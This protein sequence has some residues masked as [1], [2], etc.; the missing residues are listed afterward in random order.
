VVCAAGSL[1]LCAPGAAQQVAMQSSWQTPDSV[2]VVTKHHMILDG[3]TLSYSARAGTLPIRDNATGDVHARIF[4]VSYTLDRNEVARARPLTFVWNGGPGSSSSLVHLL[5]FGPRRIKTGDTYP[6]SPPLSE[7]EWLDNEG[8]WLGQTDLVFVDAVGTGYSRPTKAEFGSE[9]YQTPGDAESIAEFIRV[10]RTR[11]DAWDAPLFIAGESYGVTR[12]AWVA[13]ALE[14][15][16]TRLTG[17]MLFGWELPLGNLSGD[18]R[19]ALALPTYTAAAFYYRKL[20]PDL[21]TN[22]DSAVSRAA[23][24]AQTAYLPAL[25]TRD[26][27]SDAQREQVLAQL[28]RFTGLDSEQLDRK[29]LSVNTR[30]YSRQ[31][32]RNPPRTIGR[33]DSRLWQAQADRAQ[34]SGGDNFAGEV[35]LKPLGRVAGGT[36]FALLRYLR[37]DLGFKS[38]LA[39]AELYDMSGYSPAD[40]GA[41]RSMWRDD[42][43]GVDPSAPLTHAMTLNPDL[44][45]FDACGYYDL[46]SNC[47]GDDYVAAHLDP[48]LARN[49]TTGRYWGGHMMYTDRAVRLAVRRDITQFFQSALAG[50]QTS[51]ATNS[52]PSN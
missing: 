38:D 50:Q 3:R 49:I 14:R 21:Q 28:A 19:H 6:T 25:M 22:L 26:I 24:W 13:D 11:F 51:H 29:T 43:G 12:A 10:Y 30:Q 7:S 35:S 52:T 1:T 44:K 41:R 34:S 18:V 8:T 4:F 17:V 16:G 9:F 2:I 46:G 33:Y 23:A 45:I 47:I 5:G 31:L 27:L 32:L 42:G 36:S 15:R 39:Y 20:P 37:S 48:R 40:S